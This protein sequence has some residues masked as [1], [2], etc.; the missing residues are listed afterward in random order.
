MRAAQCEAPL[1]RG[2]DPT[3]ENA[4]LVWRG[5]YVPWVVILVR[6]ELATTTAGVYRALS[7][8]DMTCMRRHEVCWC[9][10]LRP[11]PCHVPLSD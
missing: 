11:G 7:S 2:V 8:A 4:S 10:A 3:G 1:D 6:S 9:S 5:S